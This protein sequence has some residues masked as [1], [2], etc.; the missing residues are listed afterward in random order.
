MS[1]KGRFLSPEN[2]LKPWKVFDARI[3]KYG[4]SLKFEKREEMKIKPE[5][6]PNLAKGSYPN[7]NTGTISPRA[8][9]HKIADDNGLETNGFHIKVLDHNQKG[10]HSVAIQKPLENEIVMVDWLRFSFKDL[11]FLIDGQKPEENDLI[12]R[13]SLLST[14]L[15][16]FGITKKRDFGLNGFE[17]TFVLGDG[18]GTVSFGGD[19]MRGS[20]CFDISGSG[21]AGSKQGWERRVFDFLS[22]SFTIGGKINRIDLAYDDFEGEKVTV[23]KFLDFH[24]QG[25][26]KH[27]RMPSCELKGDWVH[28]NGKGRSF[29]VGTRG[30][31]RTYMRCYEKGK[32]L[33][34]KKSSWARVEIEFIYKSGQETDFSIL[35]NPTAHFLGSYKFFPEFFDDSRPVE[36]AKTI[37]KTAEISVEKTR[38]WIKKMYGKAIFCLRGLAEN[39]TKLLDDL[40]REVEHFSE[41]PPAFQVPDYQNCSVPVHLQKL[42]KEPENHRLPIMPADF[43]KRVYSDAFCC[44]TVRIASPLCV[45]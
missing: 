39:D 41:M 38:N 15:F 27:T 5:N 13:L 26:F 3:L 33:G 25:L 43:G 7:S 30:E 31:S 20:I 12:D 17:K 29:C 19:H 24:K 8:N 42:K 18:L 4:L 34:D 21:C 11:T 1:A 6:N 32:Q 10:L 23:D 44:D 9:G 45:G 40:Q 16:G 36:R 28:P 22:S 14:E 35:T 2:G 37:L